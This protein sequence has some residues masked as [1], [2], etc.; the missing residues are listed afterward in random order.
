MSRQR[1][2]TIKWQRLL[3]DGRT[4]PRCGSTEAEL[5]KAV[6]ALR[7]ALAPLEVAVILEKGVLPPGQFAQDPMQSNAISLNGRRL[8]EWLG[9]RAGQSACCDVCGPNDCRTLEVS[10]E[11]HEVI[12]AGLII[13]AGLLAAARLFDGDADDRA[14]CRTGA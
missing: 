5:D 9:A 3:A 4:C 12:P 1:T 6:A 2:L 8:E 10:G 7:Q 13:K 11:V 14:P